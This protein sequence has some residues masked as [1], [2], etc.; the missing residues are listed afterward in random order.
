VPSCV[1]K[2]RPLLR[3]PG[4]STV[5]I[6]PF[7][8]SLCFLFP[9]PSFLSWPFLLFLALWQFPSRIYRSTRLASVKMAHC[10]LTHPLALIIHSDLSTYQSW[11]FTK[12]ISYT[13]AAS[14]GDPSRFNRRPPR[15]RQGGVREKKRGAAP[16]SH[17]LSV[18]PPATLPQSCQNGR[19]LLSDEISKRWL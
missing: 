13:A 4:A 10:L 2:Q 16:P 9:L 17:F 8:H 18:P 1:Y 6:C 5:C 14:E 19:H 15:A 11:L 3:D 12:G 7:L